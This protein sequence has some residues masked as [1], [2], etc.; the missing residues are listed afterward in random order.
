M[1]V[2]SQYVANSSSIADGAVS[3]AK[4]A[5]QAC[6]VA[7]MKKEGTSGH[8]LTSNG[9]GAVP[10]YQAPAAVT[11]DVVK[12]ESQT[13][14]STANNIT[15]SSL[16]TAYNKFNINIFAK[17]HTDANS[18]LL[19]QFNA[20]TGNNYSNMTLYQQTTTLTNDYNATRANLQIIADPLGNGTTA[21][22]DIT[23]CNMT[24]PAGGNHGV[25]SHSI[26]GDTEIV[27]QSGT[28][29]NA[30]KITSIKLYLATGNFA[31]GTT[32]VIYG[33]K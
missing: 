3:E 20:D 8:V 18:P 14:A 24:L 6:S 19:M 12:I 15:F 10:S 27:M 32:A 29:I 2:S 17:G 25:V 21:S 26:R 22:S 1:G 31:V 4:L 5:S 23:I 33:F 11:L 28:W 13:L 16:D 30:N 7:K 9:A